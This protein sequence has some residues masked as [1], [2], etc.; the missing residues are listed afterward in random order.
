MN[1][2]E[3]NYSTGLSDRTKNMLVIVGT[4]GA[5]IIGALLIYGI[6][7]TPAREPYRE[8]LAQYQN[9]ARTNGALTAAGANLNA[10]SATDEQFAKNIEMAQKAL[11]SV[12][13]EN[14]ALGKESVLTSGEGKALYSAFNKKLQTYLAYNDGVLTSMLEV[15]PVLYECNQQ[16]EGLTE[17]EE[18]V[19]A[20]RA[21]AQQ[22]GDVKDVPDRDYQALAA[23]FDEGYVQLASIL[24]DIV[25]LKEP[26]GTNKA[27]Y[28]A[29]VN[30]RTEAI[31]ELSA[32]SSDFSDEVRKH[33]NAVSVTDVSDTLEEYLEAKSRVF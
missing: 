17:S 11:V 5:I 29:L 33:R 28:D 30:E 22:F 24:E 18:S 12:K 20:L 21:C 26:K 32:I 3:P 23:S 10:N 19:A 16:M 2:T 7:V 15:R 14:D 4:L 8:A 31:K 9:V 1:P 6:L 25:A 27:Q 13:T